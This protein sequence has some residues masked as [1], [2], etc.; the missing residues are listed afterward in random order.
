[1]EGERSKIR[2]VQMDTFRG[3]LGIRIPN[4][5]RRLEMCILKKLNEAFSSDIGINEH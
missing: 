2:V 1:M 3:L 5:M 4:G